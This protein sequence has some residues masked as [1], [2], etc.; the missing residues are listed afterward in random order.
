[1]QCA[2]RLNV[3]ACVD[4]SP[5]VFVGVRCHVCRPVDPSTLMHVCPHS[6]VLELHRRC[7]ECVYSL[8]FGC[9]AV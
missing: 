8:Y 4:P 9:A 3:C 6:V 7:A 5:G 2:V 1:M